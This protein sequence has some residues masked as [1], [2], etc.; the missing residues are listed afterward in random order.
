[1][2][3]KH[4]LVVSAENN[5]YTG[6]QCKLFYYSCVT[7]LKHQPIIIVHDSGHD[8]HPDFHELAKAGCA[9]QRAPGYRFHGRGDD[10]ACRNT[11]GTL[12]HAGKLF[13][14][15]D[16]LIVL[17]DSDMI[18]TGPVQ[19]PQVLSG[20]FS[21][22][23]NYDRDFVTEA[24]ARLGIER[25][26]L[27]GEKHSLCCCVP[28]VVPV[29][30]AQELGATWLKAID[31]F[32]PRHWE[33]VMYAFGL[34]VLK[35]GLKLHIS[36]LANHNFWPDEKVSASI[37]HYAYG[38]ERWTKRNYFREDQMY[39]LW[40]PTANAAEG[41]ILGELLKQIREAREFYRDVYFPLGP[42]RAQV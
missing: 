10:Y 14:D 11:P 37:I 26:A 19:F 15:R 3:G 1:M 32:T 39:G 40:N 28:H 24:L 4:Q 27:D 22:F 13:A 17:C 42:G 23:M 35:L 5:A 25:E 34:S 16:T 33:D 20:E 31:A 21:S 38:D 6:W 12:M 7:R 9:V 18:F 29:T 2:T 30:L 8:L 41:T 36:H